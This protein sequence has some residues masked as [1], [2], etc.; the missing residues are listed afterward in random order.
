MRRKE[1][2]LCILLFL[3]AC[4]ASPGPEEGVKLYFASTRDSG[5]SLVALPYQGEEASPS[6]DALLSALLAGPPENENASSPFPRGLS[7]LSWELRA[8]GVLSLDLSEHYSG[9]SDVSLTL[10]DYCI[11]LTLGYYAVSCYIC[12]VLEKR[13]FVK[14]TPIYNGCRQTNYT[15]YAETARRKE[16]LVISRHFMIE[17]PVGST[18]AFEWYCSAGASKIDMNLNIEKLMRE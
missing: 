9:L 10:A 17:V 2:A 8:D 18:F 6:V 12:T 16:M 13:G 5:A 15:T 14:V 7:V 3:T 1:L 4:R 11:V